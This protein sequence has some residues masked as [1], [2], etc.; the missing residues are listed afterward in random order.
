MPLCNVLVYRYKYFTVQHRAPFVVS[1]TVCRAASRRWFDDRPNIDIGQLS[2]GSRREKYPSNEIYNLSCATIRCSKHA[3][4]KL[5]LACCIQ[6]RYI[7][8]LRN[9]ENGF[10]GYG[11]DEWTERVSISLV[12]LAP[13]PLILLSSVISL[14]FPSSVKQFVTTALR[15]LSLR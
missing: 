1:I 14:W 12:L 2:C 6:A 8:R 10:R 5:S 15:Y 9:C 4:R 13:V 3:A 11:G 7:R